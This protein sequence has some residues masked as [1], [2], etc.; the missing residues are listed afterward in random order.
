MSVG[1]SDHTR[2]RRKKPP[3]FSFII[4]SMSTKQKHTSKSLEETRI[5]AENFLRS[6]K[7][8]EKAVVIALIG[9]LGSGKTAFSQAIGQSLGVRD[10]IQSP[11]FLIEKIYELSKENWEHLIHIDAY[12]LEREE[13]L[14]HLGWKEIIKRPG[15]LIL[16]EWADK[17]AGILPEET[18]YIHFSFIDEKTRAI[19]I[20]GKSKDQ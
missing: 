13:E 11:T 4:G 2:G 10:Y 8:A 7:P 15:N 6:L 3:P 20:N 17:V 14:L 18:I 16:V 19:E 12:R 5:I 9:D 1:P